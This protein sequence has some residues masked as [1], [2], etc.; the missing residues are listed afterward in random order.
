MG[1]INS[2]PTGYNSSYVSYFNQ[3]PCIMY[4][5]LLILSIVGSFADGP[6][7]DGELPILGACAF[8]YTLFG[9]VDTLP[10][11][12]NPDSPVYSALG[13]EAIASIAEELDPMEQDLFNQFTF[14]MLVDYTSTVDC[15]AAI[16]YVDS[17]AED[18][19]RE[20]VLEELMIASAI[21]A[22]YRIEAMSSEGRRKLQDGWTTE[23]IILT[24]CLGLGG[25]F[26]GSLISH[27][28]L[29]VDPFHSDVDCRRRRL[30]LQNKIAE[31]S[32]RLL[33]SATDSQELTNGHEFSVD[34]GSIMEVCANGA[35]SEIC[36]SASL[37]TIIQTLTSSL[38]GGI[39]TGLVCTVNF[40]QAVA[41][42]S[43]P[44][45]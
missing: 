45:N 17:L 19:D 13:D 23:M 30:A 16:A 29:H 3:K 41:A 35:P 14:Q 6:I 25:F 44:S 5:L 18:N 31:A 33:N 9:N 4:F 20:T 24:A 36:T 8:Q 40:S 15:S 34:M 37:D 42:I 28:T 22:A 12:I 2:S 38:C 7:A 21:D 43:G 26:L 39:V 11:M 10:S 32:R 27:G 1:S